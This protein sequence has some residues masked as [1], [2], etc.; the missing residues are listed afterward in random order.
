VSTAEAKKCLERCHGLSPTV[1][2]K[3]EL[4]K[5]DLQ[6]TTAYAMVGTDDPLLEIANSAIGQRSDGLA[7]LLSGKLQLKLTKRC[8]ERHADH[9]PIL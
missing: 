2:P 4:V 9:A 5:V 1:V 7:S 3:D 6:V 8:W